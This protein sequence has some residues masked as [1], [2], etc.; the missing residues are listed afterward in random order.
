MIQEKERDSGPQDI[1]FE[2][3]KTSEDF[4][5]SDNPHNP[6][7]ED[8]YRRLEVSS[9]ITDRNL[10]E[11]CYYFGLSP[12]D[13]RGKKILDVGSGRKETFSKEAANYDAEVYSVSPSL[14]NWFARKRTQGLFFHDSR[15]PG[16]SVAARAHGLPF[17]DQSFDLV[18]ALYSV[19][20]YSQGET[21]DALSVMDMARVVKKGGKVLI[22]P[23]KGLKD[24]DVSQEEYLERQ[25]I[26]TLGKDTVEWLRENGY[27][28]INIK[29]GPIVVERL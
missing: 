7:L 19:P 29:G 10:N 18:T 13:L 12:E 17:K 9:N 27:R 28:V 22:V 15:W 6:S 24:K 11:Y 26:R 8:Y 5:K 1:N 14:K 20:Y 2:A 21:T 4:A 16:R 3:P 23:K 25:T